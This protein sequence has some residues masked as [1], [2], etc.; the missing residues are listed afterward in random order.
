MTCLKEITKEEQKRILLFQ[1]H[2]LCVGFD[3]LLETDEDSSG[4]EGP[5]EF[6]KGRIFSRLSR[7]VIFF[8]FYTIINRICF[9]TVDAITVNRTVTP[10]SMD[11][12]QANQAYIKI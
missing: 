11:S 5:L 2:S 9:K 3:V 1:V 6:P 12:L 4:V 10:T 7:F 8:T